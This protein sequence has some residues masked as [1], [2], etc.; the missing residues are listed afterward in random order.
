METRITKEMTGFRSYLVS[1]INQFAKM[2]QI[3]PEE[4]ADGQIPNFDYT[5]FSRMANKIASNVEK[6]VGNV[7][8]HAR[9][10][11]SGEYEEINIKS[12]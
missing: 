12:N 4:I 9:Q 11:G 6:F 3:T 7:K 1:S 8:E 2:Y 10:L 5:N